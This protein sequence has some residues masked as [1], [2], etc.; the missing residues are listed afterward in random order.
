MQ[1]ETEVYTVAASRQARRGMEVIISRWWWAFAL[2]LAAGL[3]LSLY[4]WR[5]LLAVFFLSLVIY[6]AIL[7]VAYYN[8]ALSPEAAS[9]LKPHRMVLDSN[10]MRLVYCNPDDDS[11][12]ESVA[13]V[14]LADVERV[15]ESSYGFAIAYRASD[16]RMRV[17]EIPFAAFRDSADLASARE[18]LRPY[19]VKF[20]HEPED[21]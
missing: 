15:E 6:P 12:A 11:E 10:M 8:C 1:V 13:E 2:P 7:A 4:D 19:F 18:L 14:P 5:I 9:E 3:V 16:R 17:S 21:N 20:E